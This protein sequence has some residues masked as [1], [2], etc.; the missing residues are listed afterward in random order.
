MLG[1]IETSR[2]SRTRSRPFSA[3]SSYSH[4]TEYRL[5]DNESLNEIKSNIHKTFDSESRA[6]KEVRGLNE[7]IPQ[8]YSKRLNRLYDQFNINSS[9]RNSYTSDVD[10]DFI[11]K[12]FILSKSK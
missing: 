5:Q 11:A 8:K 12:R 6:I 3:M 4:R 10:V 9:K 7:Q 2:S 1:T